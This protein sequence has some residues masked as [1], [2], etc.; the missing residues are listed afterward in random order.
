MLICSNLHGSV[1][2][3]PAYKT[4]PPDSMIAAE[5]LMRLAGPG[6][7]A[8]HGTPILEEGHT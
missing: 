4:E 2:G 3:L 6:A 8:K 7:I 1:V 5:S